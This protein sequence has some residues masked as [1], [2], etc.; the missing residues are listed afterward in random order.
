MEKPSKKDKTK[1]DTIIKPQS[2]RNADKSKR[3]VQG[4]STL[5]VGGNVFSQLSQ[6]YKSEAPSILY[7]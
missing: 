4:P 6:M 1:Q 7:N 3:I 2:L 5:S